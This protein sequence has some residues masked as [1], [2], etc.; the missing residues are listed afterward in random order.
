MYVFFLDPLG[1]AKLGSS[2][3]WMLGRLQI[4]SQEAACV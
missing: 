4:A 2:V 1:R 3:W